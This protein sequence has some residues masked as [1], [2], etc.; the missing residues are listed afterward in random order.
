MLAIIK[1]MMAANYTVY[2]I[3]YKNLANFLPRPK[4]KIVG[5]RFSTDL[6]K[7]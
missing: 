7:I 5:F 1:E 3:S 4:K 2:S 6:S